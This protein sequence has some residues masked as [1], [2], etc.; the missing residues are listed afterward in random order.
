MTNDEKNWLAA[1]YALG[2]MRGAEKVAFEK[3][4][5]S[6]PELA[7]L[8]I[9]WQERLRLVQP[10]ASAFCPTLSEAEIDAALAK[11]FERVCSAV[12][13]ESAGGV[14][15]SNPLRRL[16]TEQLSAMRPAVSRLIA[17]YL[18]LLE[19]L[20]AQQARQASQAGFAQG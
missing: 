1:D 18:V 8:L 4:L 19:R 11:V 9:Q 3:Q 10:Q 20:K 14:D 15:T 13:A 16:T 17:S 7:R 5:Q 12:D 2:V 6:D